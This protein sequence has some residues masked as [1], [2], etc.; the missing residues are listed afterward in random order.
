MVTFAIRRG[1]H[2]HVNE[3]RRPKKRVDTFQNPKYLVHILDFSPKLKNTKYEFF[4]KT[5]NN[6]Y[7]YESVLNVYYG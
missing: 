1:S 6:I 3:S 7:F 2:K 5:Q 4:F